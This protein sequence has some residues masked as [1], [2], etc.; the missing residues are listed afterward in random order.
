MQKRKIGVIWKMAAWT[1][2]TDLLITIQS[3]GW[4]WFAPLETQETNVIPIPI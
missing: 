1:L 2:E 4:Q 3:S